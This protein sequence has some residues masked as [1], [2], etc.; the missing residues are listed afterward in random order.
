MNSF[1]DVLDTTGDGTATP[2]RIAKL[3]CKSTILRQ[4]K[5][6]IKEMVTILQDMRKII[7]SSSDD[8]AE[9]ARLY[10]EF[11]KLMMSNRFTYRMV[12]N[13]LAAA[14][15]GDFLRYTLNGEKVSNLIMNMPSAQVSK[16]LAK[17]RIGKK[18]FKVGAR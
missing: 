8:K 18:S 15:V 1:K 5:A 12:Y 4:N 11:G 13:L 16:N 17:K 7:V 14:D 3:E 9:F 10:R 2:V 6:K